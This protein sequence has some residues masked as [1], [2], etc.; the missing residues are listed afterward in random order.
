MKRDVST[1]MHVRFT[2]AV[3][4]GRVDKHWFPR[5]QP[6][7][8]TPTRI[9][10]RTYRRSRRVVDGHRGSTERTPVRR[11]F[12][13]A[14]PVLRLLAADVN[15]CTAP[16][17]VHVRRHDGSVGSATSDHPRRPPGRA[18]T[19]TR[20]G[21]RVSLDGGGGGGGGDFDRPTALVNRRSDA[22]RV[23]GPKRVDGTY[24]FLPRHGHGGMPLLE[25]PP[26]QDVSWNLRGTSWLRD[27]PPLQLLVRRRAPTDDGGRR[28]ETKLFAARLCCRI[29]NLHVVRRGAVRCGATRRDDGLKAKKASKAERRGEQGEWKKAEGSAPTRATAY[30]IFPIILGG[31]SPVLFYSFATDLPAT[32]SAM[33][34]QRLLPPP[35]ARGIYSSLPHVLHPFTAPLVASQLQCGF[36]A[37]LINGKVEDVVF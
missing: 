9:R 15:R 8:P 1:K 27:V 34:Q 29:F 35:L 24:F 37:Y 11:R 32:R 6:E 5:N 2:I 36:S 3:D 14:P 30:S 12:V 19:A 28:R 13:C 18:S 25:R 33:R 21:D 10:V 20:G 17:T 23:F 16:R 22:E 7:F 31:D 26:C 4:L